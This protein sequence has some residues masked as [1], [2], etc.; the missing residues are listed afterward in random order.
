MSD[1]PSQPAPP[2]RWI[3]AAAV[4]LVL[5]S[6]SIRSTWEQVAAFDRAIAA[7]QD[8]R[9]DDAIV[10]YRWTMRWTTPWGPRDAAAAAALVR[11][12]DAA[13]ASRPERAAFAL[14][15]A[16]SGAI[17]SRWLLQ[18]HADILA[19]ANARL[20]GLWLRVAERRGDPRDK[21]ALRRRLEAD[22]ARPVG[23]PGWLALLVALGFGLWT[24]GLW[25]G[26]SRGF[27]EQGRFGPAGWRWLAASALG[28]AT[29]ATALWLG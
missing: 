27:D 9:I 21:D 1:T 13:E 18:P 14:D 29:W 4:L 11:I 10:E 7:E 8:G 5:L 19:A 28:M 16:R 22:V 20:P 24:F 2:A 23:V 15:A 6:L 3:A 25:R 26:L 12:A 17:A